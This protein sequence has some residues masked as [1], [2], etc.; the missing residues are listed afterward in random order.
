MPA[1]F[2]SHLN[3]GKFCCWVRIFALFFERVEG[4][5]HAIFRVCPKIYGVTQLPT[6][7]FGHSLDGKPKSLLRDTI[8]SINQRAMKNVACAL[9]FHILPELE[10]DSTLFTIL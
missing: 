8:G 7:I 2:D 6:H 1:P 9:I 10:K 4:F 5:M 3:H